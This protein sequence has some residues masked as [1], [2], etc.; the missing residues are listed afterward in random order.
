M[1]IIS[2]LFFVTFAGCPAVPISNE[3]LQVRHIQPN[4]SSTCKFIRVI[5]VS[6]G[7]FCS[8]LP[9]AKRDMPAKVRNAVAS[10]D[11]NA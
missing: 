6:G 7:M 5:E 8:S 9:E 4:D 2:V 3:G 1:K 10:I 11:G